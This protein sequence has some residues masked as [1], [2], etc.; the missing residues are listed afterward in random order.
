M[1][2]SDTPMKRQNHL[3]DKKAMIMK[4]RRRKPQI[5]S[6]SSVQRSSM[7]NK[8]MKMST[9]RGRATE[10]Q[11]AVSPLAFNV[12]EVIIFHLSFVSM[13][14]FQKLLVFLFVH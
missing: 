5:E 9:H 2:L 6:Y 7:S 4:E 13:L 8:Q 11:R 12:C 14:G 10:K 1:T 3:H